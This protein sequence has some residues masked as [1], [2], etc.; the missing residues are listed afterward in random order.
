MMLPSVDFESTASTIPPPGPCIGDKV[1]YQIWQVIVHGV[2]IL[3]R[4][5]A[6]FK[7]QGENKMDRGTN[8]WKARMQDLLYVC[9]DEVKR[10]TVI[11]KKMIS[12]SRISTSLNRAYEEL[13]ELASKELKA[14][15]LEWKHPQVKRILETIVQ[16]ESQ[17]EEVESEVNDIRFSEGEKKP[18]DDT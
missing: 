10:T 12:A 13:G 6:I 3:W 4:G 9:R 8:N 1:K 18:Q 7:I 16:C 2:C 17:L 15:K 14:G 11:G 5:K